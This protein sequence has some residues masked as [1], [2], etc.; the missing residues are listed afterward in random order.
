MEIFGIEPFGLVVVNLYPF[1]ETVASGAS[2]SQCIEKIDVGGPT[3]VRGAAK[4]HAYVGVL[5][6]P[7]DYEPV[8]AELQRSGKLSDGTRLQLAISAFAH[9]TTYDSVVFNWLGM[10]QIAIEHGLTGR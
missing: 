9:T 7:A 6:D 2:Y 5:T 10:Q 4:N 8:L 3:M 1:I